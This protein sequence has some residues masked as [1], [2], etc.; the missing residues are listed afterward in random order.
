MNNSTPFGM[1]TRRSVHEKITFQS[2]TRRSNL[3]TPLPVHSLNGKLPILI[4]GNVALRITKNFYFREKRS[5]ESSLFLTSA[6]ETD[7][8]LVREY[9][10]D[11]FINIEDNTNPSRPVLFFGLYDGHG[12]GRCAEFLKQHLHEFI[13]KDPDLHSDTKNVILRGFLK[14]ENQFFEEAKKHGYDK[15]GSCGIISLIIKDKCYV[16]KQRDQ[17]IPFVKRP[18]AI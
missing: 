18:Q 11:K 16:A 17:N 7:K 1:R 8:G 4:K 2:P 6:S 9:N 12:G 3:S 13:L 5:Q 14:A 10:E 15:S